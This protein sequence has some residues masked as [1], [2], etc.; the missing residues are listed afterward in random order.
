MPMQK[1]QLHRLMRIAALLKEN[2][3]PNSEFLVKEFRRIAV[4]EELDI[5]CG[6]KTIL[7]D[8]KV[9]EED[10]GCPLAF[11]RARNGY[12]LKHHGWDFIAPALLDENEM[13]AAV[14]G[15]RIA[16][17]IFP[18]PLKN[19][20]RN[21]VD[22]LLQ[23]NNP[24]FLDTA[25]ME[26]LN[27]LSGLYANIEPVIFQTIFLGWQS[28]RR[29]KISYANWQGVLTE[30]IIEPHTLVFFNNSWYT[31]AF[32]RLKKQPRTFALLRIKKAELL[33]G[34][35][36]PDRDIIASVNPD[37]FLGFEKITNVKLRAV[38]YALDRLKSSPLHTHQVIHEDGSV[39][40]PAVAKEV[41]F[42]FILSQ[43]GNVQLLE[44]AGLKAELKAT[45]LKMLEQC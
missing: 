13:L 5:D 38:S 10:F 12:Y 15:A 40:I 8:M 31:K 37:D 26:S 24:D 27:I 43:E 18:A 2:R 25:N 36:E 4:E 44:P 21:A 19:K 3:Y 17:E 22:Y 16:E 41:L 1:S 30:R 11:D 23:N 33:D 9:L 28:H 29:V 20:I 32:C 34:V 45:L 14:I 35:F 39:E 6:K 42:P 7:R